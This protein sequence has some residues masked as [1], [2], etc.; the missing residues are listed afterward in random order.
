[1]A[2][3]KEPLAASLRAAGRRGVL[4]VAVGSAAAGASWMALVAAT[5]VGVSQLQRVRA[6]VTAGA[7]ALP[8]ESAGEYRLVVH[9]YAAQYVVDGVPTPH[10]RPLASTQR[11]V[12]PWEL[13][14]GV[15]VDVVDLETRTDDGAVI[16]AWVEQGAANLE[17]DGRRARPS[18]DA[19]VGVAATHGTDGGVSAQLVLSRRVG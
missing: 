10:A 3:R 6:E 4:G 2:S 5:T 1:M 11:S 14:R 7:N 12:T 18:R 15:A 17:F 19:I 16:V 13:S 8:R 9:S